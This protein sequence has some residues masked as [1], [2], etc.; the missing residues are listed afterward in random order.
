MRRLLQY[1]FIVQIFAYASIFDE[2]AITQSII[3]LLNDNFIKFATFITCASDAADVAKSFAEKGMRLKVQGPDKAS[4]VESLLD[5]KDHLLAVIVDYRCGRHSTQFLAQ[6]S[7]HKLFT[8]LHRFLLLLPDQTKKN[9]LYEELSKLD[10]PIYSQVTVASYKQGDVVVELQ[11]VY[12]VRKEV[13]LTIT[14]VQKWAPG[15]RFPRGPKRDNFGGIVFNSSTVLLEGEAWET[16]LAE[17]NKHINTLT[18]FHF[19]LVQEIARMLNFRLYTWPETSWGYPNGTNYDGVIGTLQRGEAEIA[20]VALILKKVRMDYL[21]YVGETVRYEG[22]FYFLKPSLSDVSNIYLLPFS[23]SVWITYTLAGFIFAVVF[24]WTQRIEDAMHQHELHKTITFTDSALIAIS[25]VCQEGSSRDPRNLSARIL[26][27]SLLLLS[28]FLTV[29]Y[30]AI[31]VSLLQTTSD[32]IK[33][34]RD[35][36]DSPFKLGMKDVVSNHRYVNET[37]DQT[38]KELYFKHIFTQPWHEA[39]T[40][41]KVGV[42]RMRSQLYAF[43]GDTDAL[44]EIGRTFEEHEKCRLNR[45]LMFTSTRLSFCA[46]KGSP[47]K[48]LLRR[49][50]Q[51]LKEAGIIDREYKMWLTQKPACQGGVEGFASVRIKDFYPALLVWI[52]GLIFSTAL[53]VLEYGRNKLTHSRENVPHGFSI[54]K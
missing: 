47:Y 49:K 44:R 51:W 50:A 2:E 18:K 52:Y 26:F 4:D 36:M 9:Q 20:S 54:E 42:D 12:R 32:S 33:S 16:F 31:I 14:P 43:H 29:S 21:D 5:P 3:S 15:E 13:P 35:L 10:L 23:R 19:V 48:E 24:Y 41:T 37:K 45:V 38:I 53:L 1:C 46:R 30:S 22:A 40:S 17:S 11:D 7:E 25:V 8:S 27:L 39:F 34:I 28:L 6:V